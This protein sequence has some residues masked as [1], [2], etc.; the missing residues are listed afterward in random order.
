[1]LLIDQTQLEN[2]F[3]VLIIA[4]LLRTWLKELKT[5]QCKKKSNLQQKYKPSYCLMSVV[6]L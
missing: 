5:R 1:M 2:V 4:K 6:I 3:F